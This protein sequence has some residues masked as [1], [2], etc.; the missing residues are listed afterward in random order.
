MLEKLFWISM[1]AAC[2]IVVPAAAQEDWEAVHVQVPEL[3]TAAATPNCSG[4]LVYDDGGYETVYSLGPGNAGTVMRFDL[5]AGTTGL[6]Q[7]CTCFSRDVG[8][9][10]SMSFQVVVYDNN[11][12][13]GGPGTLLGTVNAT[14]SSIPVFPAAQYY[15]VNLAASGITLPDQNVFAGVIWPG[16]SP[17]TIYICGDRTAS[18]P[19]R[20]IF[21]SG[22]GGSS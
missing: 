11:G 5:P 14:A 22:N 10:S 20:T 17:D 15:N 3:V 16:G 9:P 21:G 18:T 1:A 19:Q 6:D 13:G 8:A 2:L 7:V 12:T 4:G